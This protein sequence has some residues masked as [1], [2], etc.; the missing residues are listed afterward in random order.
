MNVTPVK[1]RPLSAWLLIIFVLIL[2]LGATISG[3]M[4]F[5][6]PNGDLMGMSTS[7]LKGSPFHNYVIP[8]I[9]LFLFVGVFPFIVA[10]GLIIT[11]WKGLHFLNPFPAHHWAWTGSITA[12]VILIIWIIT[13]TA[14]L[15]NISVLQPVMAAWGIII[16]LLT[17]VPDLRKYYHT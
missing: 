9:I 11:G 13:E 4:L 7:L 3:A 5:I 12:G 2:G 14:L 17:A 15:G 1:I 16:I 8:G 10:M 6:K